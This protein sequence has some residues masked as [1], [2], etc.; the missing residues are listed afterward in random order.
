MWLTKRKLSAA[1]ETSD[2]RRVSNSALA[3][4]YRPRLQNRSPLLQVD[5]IGE[6]TQAIEVGAG[7]KVEGRHHPV[8]CLAAFAGQIVVQ[9]EVRPGGEG[10]FVEQQLVGTHA[11]II[12]RVFLGGK[13]PGGVGILR[14][15]HGKLSFADPKIIGGR[16]VA[17]GGEHQATLED[18][19]CLIVL[20]EAIACDAGQE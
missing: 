15:A 10:G 16:I 1:F 3:S 20:S 8:F 6:V 9:I 4:V 14:F 2:W 19:Q 17:V 18:G 7:R 12:R 11:V 5:I 13:L